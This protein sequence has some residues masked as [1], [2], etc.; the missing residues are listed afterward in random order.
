MC[1]NPSLLPTGQQVACRQCW[2]C[3]ENRIQDWTG[4]S[5]AQSKTSTVTRSVTLTYGGGDH[6]AATVLT[7]SDVQ[8]Y[9]KR[10]RKAGFKFKYLVAG[11]YGGVKGRAHWHCIFFFDGPA[12]EHPLRKNYNCPY[13][14]HGFTFWDEATPKAL[15][16]VCKYVY[17]DVA[18]DE[19]Q[20][21][22]AMSK[23]PPLGSEYFEQ[24]AQS[25]VDQGL[26]PQNLKYQFSEN[27]DKDGKTVTHYMHG[28]T[29][30]DFL[31]AFIERWIYKWGYWWPTSV[32]VE[33]HI[34]KYTPWAP[35]PAFEVR[36]YGVRPLRLP[37]DGATLKFS[38]A[39]NLHYCD[40]DDKRYYWR[41]TINNSE[42][43]WAWHD[44]NRRVV[45]LGS[46]NQRTGRTR[47]ATRQSDVPILS[48]AQH[49]SL[50]CRLSDERRRTKEA[51][52]ASAKRLPMVGDHWS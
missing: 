16:Y 40:I 2:Q 29:A 1:I 10:L 36:K 27:K 18:D 21:H 5:L 6:E 22:F 47:S 48:A 8:K 9:F 4:R 32:L 52:K 25:W 38:D 30:R 43:E 28:A 37:R 49:T 33:E 39:H 45:P 24:L 44:Q 46:L 20:A 34:D 23:K 41:K 14:G 13:W 51:S 12:P 26:S 3:I 50:M 19:A 7:Y 11:E 35:D 17:K 31:N 42:S 15:R